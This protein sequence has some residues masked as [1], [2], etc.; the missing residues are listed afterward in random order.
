MYRK[1]QLRGTN[2]TLQL[3]KRGELLL[4][5]INF[6]IERILFHSS[7]SE[8]EHEIQHYSCYSKFLASTVSDCERQSDPTA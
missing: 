6:G 8:S 7:E 3:N 2:A 5:E 1:K 4:W